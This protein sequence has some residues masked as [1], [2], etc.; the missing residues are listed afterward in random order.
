LFTGSR[1][2]LNVAPGQAKIFLLIKFSQESYD[3][4]LNKIR[5]RLR[6]MECASIGQDSAEVVQGKGRVS[7]NS[8]RE[9]DSLGF[10]A[11][12]LKIVDAW[13]KRRKAA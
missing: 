6:V 9:P 2:E 11:S 8:D 5:G 3:A 7:T 13:Y 1:I 4:L 10:I 12:A